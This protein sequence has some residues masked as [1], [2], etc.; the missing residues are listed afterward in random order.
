[1]P[2][3]SAVANQ[4]IAD[5]VIGH[6][7]GI[8][9]SLLTPSS[10]M[11]CHGGDR[12]FGAEP[13]AVPVSPCQ[14][15]S[16]PV[17][18]CGRPVT[19]TGSPR[20]CSRV[21]RVSGTRCAQ[22]SWFPLEESHHVPTPTACSDRPC[23]GRVPAHDPRRDSACSNWPSRF[24]IRRPSFA[25]PVPAVAR[26][27]RCRQTRASCPRGPNARSA[28]SRIPIATRRSSFP[29]QT[30]PSARDA[31]QFHRRSRAVEIGEGRAG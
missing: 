16:V 7:V 30:S 28:T 5:I 26:T 8:Q 19:R 12:R 29:T 27:C 21:H 22:F 10:R 14:S 3:P 15:R 20:S 17:W 6:A 25:S 13:S 23:D 2:P 4:S 18:P 24:P 9:R 1:M 11:R 31:I